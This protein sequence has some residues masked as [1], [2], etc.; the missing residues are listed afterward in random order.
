MLFERQIATHVPQPWQRPSFT[1]ATVLMRLPL[2]SRIS[3]SSIAPYGHAWMHARQWTHVFSLTRAMLGS[4][5]S[6]GYENRPSTLAAQAD[7]W[8]TQSGMSFGAWHAPARKT[9]AAAVSTG[10][11]FGWASL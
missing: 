10:R 4:R 5:S 8:A 6:S 2:R 3:W 7:A 9:P 1:R 11:N